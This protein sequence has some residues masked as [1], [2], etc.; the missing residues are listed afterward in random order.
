MV[1][2]KIVGLVLVE[3]GKVTGARGLVVRRERVI[4]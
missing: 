1:V 2:V 4:H 3:E